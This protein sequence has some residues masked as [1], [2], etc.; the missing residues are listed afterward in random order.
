MM[1]EKVNKSFNFILFGA[2]GDLAYIKLFP[3]IYE[4]VLQNRFNKSYSIVGFGRS[5]L[6]DLE[7][8]KR[9]QKSLKEHVDK[10][11]Y[12]QKR[13]NE[14][15]D[16]VFYHQGQYDKAGSYQLL[17]QKLLE[18]QNGKKVYNLAFLAVPP[19]VFEPIIEGLNPI[20]KSLGELQ[21]MM[22][23]PFGNDRESAGELF[24]SITN[25]FK[26]E[27]LFLIDHYL[28][29]A[30][31]QSLL[32]LRYNNT[33]LNLLLK[34]SAIANIQISALETVGVDERVG[35][36]EKVGIVKDMIK[37]HLL[38][39]LALL[40][41]SM[42][43]H[44]DERSIRREKGNILSAL[45]YS[46]SDC[47]AVLGQYATYRKQKDVAPDSDTPTFAA[48]KCTIDMTKWYKVPIYIRTGKKLTHKH[49]YIVI[50]FEKP[51][52]KEGDDSLDANRMIIELYPQEQIQIRLVNDV[53]KVAPK[54][55]ELIS[56][57][58]LACMGEGCLPAYGRLILDAFLGH[59]N[60]FLSID[61][62]YA[63][64]HFVDELMT[65]FKKRK[66]PLVHYK[67]DS[68]G[69][70]EQYELTKADGF[71]WYDPDKL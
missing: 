3:S 41:M 45:K 12:D 6:T 51:P 55:R 70:K 60:S 49:T 63:S 66:L 69:P 38:Q 7:F 32:P 15:L 61:E 44:P 28:G 18:L 71:E 54:S 22:E 39:I 19:S 48:F 58:S 13:V 30:P 68:E 26:K 16:R 9:I 62:I 2:S 14:M 35:Y 53:G 21:V 1:L 50:E 5:D 24:K 23:K 31:I 64:W 8:R 46:G 29:K 52:F 34:G 42:P 37:S 65:C 56:H 20:R 36:F 4:L 33:I 27:D 40:T 25:R 59:H 43:L 47:G 67:D 11:I 17:A 57:E 10:K